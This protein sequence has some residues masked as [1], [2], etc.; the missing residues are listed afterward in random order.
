MITVRLTGKEVEDQDDPK[1]N[2][3]KVGTSQRPVLEGHQSEMGL[4]VSFQSYGNFFHIC[5]YT[6]LTI[7][8]KV[9]QRV[10]RKLGKH[11]IRLFM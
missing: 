2:H 7:P 4:Q 8:I 9:L 11:P 1:N 3:R 10:G 6:I 5:V